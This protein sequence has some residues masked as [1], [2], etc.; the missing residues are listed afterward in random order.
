[1]E[2]KYIN[3]RCF[4]ISADNLYKLICNSEEWPSF[5]DECI[6]GR[7]MEKKGD[8]CVRYMK[9]IVNHK[10]CEM[11]T[12]CKFIDDEHK[13]MFE[14]I[15]SPWP[16]KSNRGQWYIETLANGKNLMVLEHRVVARYGFIGDILMRLLIGK[17]FVYSHA[18]KILDEFEK[19]IGEKNI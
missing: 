12:R 14:Q 17:F 1:M 19:H 2:Y 7:I 8:Q 13:M 4:N 16:I 11:K 5:I 3:K 10:L 9:S 6:E 18:E 15:E